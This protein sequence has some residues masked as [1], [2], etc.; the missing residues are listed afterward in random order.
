MTPGETVYA[1]VWEFAND[2]FGTFQF[3]AYSPTL[4]MNTFNQSGLKVYP[5]PVKD[6][7]TLSSINSITKVTIYNLLG[8][9]VV[10]KVVIGN[11][12]QID[13]SDLSTGT[14]IAKINSA[15]QSKTIKIIKE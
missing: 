11:D 5:N 9:E 2:T 14:Y 3:S 6:I 4:A 1:R 10:S 7:L 8:Q 13:L 12:I 15:S